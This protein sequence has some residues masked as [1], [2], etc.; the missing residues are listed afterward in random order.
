MRWLRQFIMLLSLQASTR[1]ALRAVGPR[2]RCAS[3]A[4]S[5]STTTSSAVPITAISEQLKQP[6]ILEYDVAEFPLAEVVTE[7]LG[8]PREQDLRLLHESS[9][10]TEMLVDKSGAKINYYQSMWN[11][12]RDKSPAE[13]GE[14]FSRFDAL[15]RSFLQTVVAP[16]IQGND[17]GR[18]IFQRAPT[19]RVYPPGGETAMG[20]FHNDEQYHHQP[21]ELNLWMPLSLEVKGTNSLWVESSPGLAD[22]EPLSLRYGQCYR[23]YLNQCRHGCQPNNSG[24]TRVSLDFRIIADA[25]GGHNPAFRKGV[26]R[27]PKA[28]YQS[29]FDLGGFYD[30]MLR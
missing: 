9:L 4:R 21:S 12:D 25:L 27:G 20:S 11:R 15:Y 28:M 6:L 24:I 29:V 17:A 30:V 5:S 18:I 7:I 19:L 26:R 10:G 14:A 16:S 23:G 2:L 3:T 22:Y 1:S 13:R 8:L